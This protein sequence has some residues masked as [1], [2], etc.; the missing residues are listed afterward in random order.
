MRVLGLDFG[1]KTLGLAISDHTK[2]IATSLKTLRYEGDYKVLFE[3][4]KNIIKENNVDDIVIGYP[5]NMDETLGERAI[6][7]LSFKKD[8][9][10]YLNLSINLEDERLTTFEATNI[11]LEADMSRKRR[12]KLVDK[13]AASFIL[14]SYLDRRKNG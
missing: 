6:S 11:L 9:E 12:K 5:I 4:L 13:I 1:T 10:E 2:T 3:D 8:L 7:T 14:Q